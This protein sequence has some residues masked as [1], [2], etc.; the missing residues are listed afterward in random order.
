M[1][2]MNNYKSN[3]QEELLLIEE[4]QLIEVLNILKNNFS[5]L[6]QFVHEK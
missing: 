6:N 4:F 2:V 5:Q 1:K 3:D